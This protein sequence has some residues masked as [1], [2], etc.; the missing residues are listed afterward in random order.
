MAG[1]F[2]RVAEPLQF[3]DKSWGQGHNGTQTKTDE[4]GVFRVHVSF[5]GGL[6]IMARFGKLK[7]TI[8]DLEYPGSDKSKPL[9][10]QLDF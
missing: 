8:E 7:T 5:P 3:I 10:I 2:V 4:N 1:A 9:V 6:R